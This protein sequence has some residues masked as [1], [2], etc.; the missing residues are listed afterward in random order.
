MCLSFSFK[1]FWFYYLSPGQ[2]NIKMAISSKMCISDIWFLYDF[3]FIFYALSN[4]LLFFQFWTLSFFTQWAWPLACFLPL[5]VEICWIPPIFV[6][7]IS[8]S[9]RKNK[10]R[11]VPLEETQKCLIRW[12]ITIS[13]QNTTLTFYHV[14]INVCDFSLKHVNEV[15]KLYAWIIL[16]QSKA[17]RNKRMR[18]LSY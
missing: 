12:C 13:F 11:L 5:A 3:C 4:N 2:F 18:S 10:N 17:R 16:K 1:Y 6:L 14:Y 9:T 15:I 7:N 8:K